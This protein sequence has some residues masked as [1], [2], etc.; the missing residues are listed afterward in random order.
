M[1]HEPP[2]SLEELA[3]AHRFSFDSLAGTT[4][5]IAGES[6]IRLNE[7]R[8]VVRR[9]SLFVQSPLIVRR[10]ESTS[11][12]YRELSFVAPLATLFP[13]F[14]RTVKDVVRLELLHHPCICIEE[15]DIEIFVRF[16]EQLQ[17]KREQAAQAPTPLQARLAELAV[18]ATMQLVWAESLQRF[19]ERIEPQGALSADTRS[20]QLPYHFFI[21]LNLNYT[22]E[23]SVKFYADQMGLSTGYFTALIKQHTGRPP[24]QWIAYMIMMNARAL[25]ADTALSIKEIAVKLGFPEQFTFRKYFKQH[26]GVSPKN[27]RISRQKAT[28]KGAQSAPSEKK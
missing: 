25:L 28:Q 5:C 17:E 20:G 1:D 4:L 2:I 18:E 14:R 12:D 8:Y 13:I 6:S 15:A 11:E 10:T 27:F 19:A 22:R 16:A 24:S 21:L 23:R 3:A 26:E 7:R 9:G